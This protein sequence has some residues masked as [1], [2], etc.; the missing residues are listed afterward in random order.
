MAETSYMP[1]LL[2]PPDSGDSEKTRRALAQALL[3]QGM[4][5]SPIRSPWQGGARLAQALMGGLELGRMDKER[6]AQI[7]ALK[8]GFG[9]GPSIVPPP[10]AATVP[11]TV[12][13]DAETPD[14][15]TPDT[16]APDAVPVPQPRP[17]PEELAPTPDAT[18][19][20]PVVP[21][22]PAPAPG[23][24]VA[25][26]PAA[27][28]TMAAMGQ[29]VPGSAG[30]FG[31]LSTLGALAHGI[32]KVESSNNY[33]AIG[34]VTSSGDRAYGRYQVMG[35]NVPSWTKEVLGTAMTPAEFRSDPQAQDAVFNA[36]MAQNLAKYGNVDDATSVWFSGRPMS[37]A[38]N[39]SDG[40]NTVP[41]YISK[42][43]SAM[44]L[45]EAA[46]NAGAPTGAA[47]FQPTMTP[48]WALHPEAPEP[49]PMVVAS[50]GANPQ[51]AA[52]APAPGVQVAQAPVAP[53][54]PPS[55]LPVAPAARSDKADGDAVA[56]KSYV[57]QFQQQKAQQIANVEAQMAQV[58]NLAQASNDPTY[59]QKAQ[60]VYQQLQA[61]RATL[62]QQTVQTLP[63]GRLLV[64]SSDGPKIVDPRD[65]EKADRVPDGIRRLNAVGM[66]TE[67][68]KAAYANP[69]HPQHNL[70]MQTLFPKSAEGGGPKVVG[71]GATV[72]DPTSGKE[73]YSNK[74][75]SELDDETASFLA[76]RVA[77]GDTTAL[78]GLGRGAQ[79]AENIAKVQ[80]MAGEISKRMAAGEAPDAAAQRVLE[81]RADQ[82][83]RLAG[84]RAGGTLNARIDVFAKEAETAI[85]LAIEASRAVPRTTWTPLNKAIQMVQ[86]GSGDPALG[87]FVAANNAVINTYSK[88]ISGG[89]TGA[90]ADREHA[91]EMLSTAQSP[92]AYEA[93]LR[94][95]QRE[96]QVA[97]RAARSAKELG[98]QDVEGDQG[99]RG[100]SVVPGAQ[101]KSI[102]QVIFGGGAPAPVSGLPQPKSMSEYD[103]LPVGAQYIDPNGVPRTKGK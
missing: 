45:P 17:A 19:D 97:H 59:L 15:P 7:A 100:A 65:K 89:G 73:V 78:I 2:A 96:V 88:A 25:D 10:P 74:P 103:K 76:A 20:A 16:P 4:E 63:D 42:V 60:S 24:P 70:V 102:G 64:G 94:Q 68:V 23:V 91:R 46:A 34:P 44:M 81:A 35:N 28:P 12:A 30:S 43:R 27:L 50:I 31:S 18:Q 57:A 29:G 93:V 9:A 71:P 32:G 5:T 75:K 66:S 80:R 33:A 95:L 82:A 26:A 22:P 77:Q 8:G 3:Q 11:A 92:E 101:S 86:S 72:Y 37:K 58:R 85:P 51:G 90:L 56:A 79:G 99:D 21:P 62:S 61:Q 41:Q 1:T 47:A 6:A 52:Q 36:K 14:T 84:A 38:G 87:Q 49:D 48:S 13:P 39:A 55:R 53:Q 69:Q 98:K 83:G 67:E 54:T 40:Y